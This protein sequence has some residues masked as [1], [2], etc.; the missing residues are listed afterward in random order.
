MQYRPLG[1]TGLEV[2]V[3]GFGA[4][5]LGDVFGATLPDEG[6]RAVH[7]AIDHGINFFDV[8]PYY[9][10]TLAE[11]RLGKAL[12]G[13]RDR[14][15]L[16]TKCGRYDDDD[17]DFSARRVV[18]SVNESLGRLRTDYLDLIQ[19]HDIEFAD[20][21]QLIH[22]TLPALRR[23]QEAGKVRFVGISGFPCSVLCE[24]AKATQV[25]TILSYCR[26]NLLI[27]DM[28]EELTPLARCKGIGLINAAP[29]LMGILTEA[30]PPTWHPAPESFKLAGAKIVELCRRNGVRVAD[31]ALRFCLDYDYVATT[32]VGMSSTRQVEEN[33]KACAY[34]GSPG[35]MQQIRKIVEPLANLSW[36]SGRKVNTT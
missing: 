14:V 21:S 30:G 6:V 32:L 28:D 5:P 1:K 10:L 2:S 8:S 7:C 34:A 20:F 4:S 33:V 16:A 27:R 15:I 31:V 24:V 19:A 26:Y 11:A 23:L 36:P 9:G 12:E 29:L 3:L 25:D 35:M 22:E 18:A 13:K 17:F